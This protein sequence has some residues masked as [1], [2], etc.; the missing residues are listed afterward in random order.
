M[1]YRISEWMPNTRQGVSRTPDT[2]HRNIYAMVVS[3]LEIKYGTQDT[4]NSFIVHKRQYSILA[5][6]TF[7]NQAKALPF[8]S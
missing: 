6:S 7:M 5:K 8:I 1:G 4:V 2:V 3:V